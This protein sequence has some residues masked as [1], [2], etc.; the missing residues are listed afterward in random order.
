MA[1]PDFFTDEAPP[2]GSPAAAALAETAAEVYALADAF[3]ERLRAMAQTRRGVGELLLRTGER[4]DAAAAGHEAASFWVACLLCSVLD[5]D[6]QLK[7]Q[8]LSTR[9]TQTRLQA[10]RQL[11]QQLGSAQQAQGCNLM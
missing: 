9:D 5:D 10:E 2:E 11:L 7:Q 1:R 3:V 4:P 8:L 6:G